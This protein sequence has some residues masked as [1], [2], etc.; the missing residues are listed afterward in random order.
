MVSFGWRLSSAVLFG[1]LVVLAVLFLRLGMRYFLLGFI[2]RFGWKIFPV[3]CLHWRARNAQLTATADRFGMRASPI[4][5]LGLAVYSMGLALHVH[6]AAGR[7]GLTDAH[8][9][10]VRR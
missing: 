2:F 6:C 3:M 5:R 1:S 7:K 10:T 9:A 4:T 8:P